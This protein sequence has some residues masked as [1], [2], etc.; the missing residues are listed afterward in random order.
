M[1][2]DF[3]FQS[4]IRWEGG[5]KASI[6]SRENP[7]IEVSTPPEFK[8]PEGYWSPEELFLASINSCILTTFLFFVDKSF[9]TFLSYESNIEGTVSLVGGKL[10]FTTVTVRPV[11][12][13]EDEEQKEEVTKLMEKSKKY[14]LIS[15]SVNA[16]IQ[17]LSEV[18]IK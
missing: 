10:F 5:K 6:G 1:A 17:V 9:A 2:K 7:S 8:G 14:C 3:N 11:I 12:Q 13:V 16:E 4:T 18:Q 15:S